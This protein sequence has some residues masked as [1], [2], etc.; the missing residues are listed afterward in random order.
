MLPHYGL[1][2]GL[3]NSEPFEQGLDNDLY[4]AAAGALERVPDVA[5]I[6]PPD[7]PFLLEAYELDHLALLSE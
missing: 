7:E 1:P 5:W 2:G 6:D 3:V 4:G